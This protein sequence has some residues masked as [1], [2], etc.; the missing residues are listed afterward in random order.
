MKAFDLKRRLG[1]YLLAFA[2]IAAPYAQAAAQTSQEPVINVPDVVVTTQQLDA[3]RNSI[4]PET[5]SSIYSFDQAAIAEM[6]LGDSTPLNQVLLQAPGVAQDSY[7]QLHIRGDHANLQYR[8]NGVII[9]ESISG[10]G[11]TLDARFFDSVKLLTG[12]LPAEY[13]LRTAGIVDIHTKS[14]DLNPGG[15]I[16]LLAGQYGTLNPSLEYGGT[17]GGL[18]YYFTGQLMHNDLG[19]ES[20][21]A[22]RNALHDTTNQAKAFGYLSY[23]L[24]ADSRISLFLG[25]SVNRF[26]IPDNMGQTPS[27][28]IDGV[29]L[30]PNLPSSALDEHQR[31]KT[32]YAVL[33]YQGKFGL[34]VDYQVSAFSRYT[35]TL[36]SPDSIGDLIYNGVASQVLRSNFSNGVQSVISSRIND[37]HT[38]RVGLALSQEHAVSDNTSS[39]FRTDNAGVQLPGGPVTI[40]DNNSKGASLQSVYIQDEW[41]LTDALTVN[42]GLRAD[43]I[44]AYTDEGQLSPRVGAV[45]KL[46]P[47]TTLHAGYAR[48]FTPPPT[49]LVSSSSIA[50]FQNTTNAPQVTQNDPVKAERSNYYD[51]G[52]THNPAAS[53]SIGLDAYYKES[54][55]LIDEGQFGQ[56]LVFTPFN[57]SKGKVYGL[58]LT[59]TYHQGDLGAYLNIAS[60]RAMGKNIESAQFN[61]GQ[62]ELDYIAN[63]WVHLDHDQSI[64]ASAGVSYQMQKTTLAADALFGSGLRS[65]FANTDHLPAYSQVNFS[66]SRNFDVVGAGHM[67]AKVALL[68]AFDRSYEIRD[69]SG[70]G[71]GAPQFGQRRALLVMLGKDF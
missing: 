26:Q 6:P 18:D 51:L 10:F 31:E 47:Q 49:E 19:I 70:I 67:N 2:S 40:T 69:G 54:R 68:N 16:S 14:G 59:N 27:F 48:Y 24:D 43:H 62:D 34:A 71:V 32:D 35:E 15:S 63:H 17:S 42:Y 12:A 30:F 13:G 3:A 58:E 4:L 65:G 5:G 38:I 1:G 29:A 66:A 45:F 60:S 21:T 52:I 8:I 23:M 33:A 11:Q 36:F 22:S 64:T 44:A 46:S 25:T 9:P 50:L 37:S 57:Y 56:A 61:F 55:N 41:L 39:V 53:W 7:G 28:P 20:P